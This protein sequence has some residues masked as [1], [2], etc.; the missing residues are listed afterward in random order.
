MISENFRLDLHE[1]GVINAVHDLQFD[2][3]VFQW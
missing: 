2:H 1:L 3:T